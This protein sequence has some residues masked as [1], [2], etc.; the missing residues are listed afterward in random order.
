ME[1][2]QKSKKQKDKADLP[3][4]GED[5]GAGKDAS[6]TEADFSAFKTPSKEHKK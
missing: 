3:S 2:L 1:D 4:G 5:D 6:S